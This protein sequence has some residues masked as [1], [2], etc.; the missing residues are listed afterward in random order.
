M[1]HSFHDPTPRQLSAPTPAMES[2]ISA[3]NN[4]IQGA[5][6]YWVSHPGS[7]RLGYTSAYVEEA[8]KRYHTVTQADLLKKQCFV[9]RDAGE[10]VVYLSLDV[11]SSGEKVSL[12]DLWV[13]SQRIGTGWGRRAWEFVVK[14]AR[15]NECTKIETFPDP[16]AEGF[17]LKM[18]MVSTGEQVRSRVPGGPMFS[19]FEYSLE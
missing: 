14:Q 8:L 7:A 11:S 15:A 12:D 16:P 2:D 5:K 17:Y 6:R 9:I 3:I 10:I 18:G 1:V 4:L 19:R 13:D